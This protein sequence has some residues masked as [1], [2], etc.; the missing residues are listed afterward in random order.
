[1]AAPL[2]FL[3]LASML[4]AKAKKSNRCRVWLACWSP[5]AAPD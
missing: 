4:P 2:S 3:A 1:M 5:G